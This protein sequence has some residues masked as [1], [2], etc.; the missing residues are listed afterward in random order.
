MVYFGVQTLAGAIL[1]L[2]SFFFR[3]E[4]ISLFQKAEPFYQMLT[5]ILFLIFLT[6]YH[7][8]RCYGRGVWYLWLLVER[9]PAAAD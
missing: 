4:V 6:R 2:P 5:R 9:R 1:F 7:W 3:I 8:P